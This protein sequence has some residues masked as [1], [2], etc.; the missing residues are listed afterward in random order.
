ME[1][2]SYSLPIVATNVGDNKY[3]INENRNG[4]LVKVKDYKQ[5]AEKINQLA[6]D[7]KKRSHFGLEGRNLLER[8]YS[9]NA[10]KNKY[11]RF[12]NEVLITNNY[13]DER[14]SEK[15]Q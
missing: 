14:F 5:I 9:E 15:K 12:L 1:A 6:L 8:N 11:I 2:L 10:L 13:S 3:L 7:E 4:Y